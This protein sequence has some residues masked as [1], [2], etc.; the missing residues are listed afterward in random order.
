MTSTTPGAV[1]AVCSASERSNPASTTPLKHDMAARAPRRGPVLRNA[2]IV[3]QRVEDCGETSSSRA[4]ASIGIGR[5]RRRFFCARVA[6]HFLLQFV[7]PART[8][9]LTKER[10]DAARKFPKSARRQLREHGTH[11]PDLA[12]FNALAARE[13]APAAG[14]FMSFEGKK[15]RIVEAGDPTR[16][17]RDLR[18]PRHE[19]RALFRLRRA[20]RALPVRRQAATRPSASHCPN[21]PT[22]SGTAICRGSGRANSTATASTAPTTRRPATASTPTSC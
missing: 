1:A 5:A 19:L 15:S 4:D 9:D 3:V 8:P 13:S 17:R 20:R 2:A 21:T 18:R 22:R 14:V 7:A 11:A 10:D 6:M 16:S 12:L